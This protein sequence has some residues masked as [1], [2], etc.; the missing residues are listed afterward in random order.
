LSDEIRRALGAG[1]RTISI[2]SPDVI[3]RIKSDFAQGVAA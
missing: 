3:S 1:S 2:I